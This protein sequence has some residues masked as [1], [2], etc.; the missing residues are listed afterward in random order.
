MIQLYHFTPTRS[1]AQIL[2]QGL[3]PSYARGNPRLLWACDYAR[4]QWAFEH[5]AECHGVRP[6]ALSL[7]TFRFSEE[8]LAAFSMPGVY[9][10]GWMIGKALLT[11]LPLYSLREVARQ[12]GIANSTLQYW[13]SAG[14]IAGSLTA[15]G[16]HMF[17]PLDIADVRA[18]QGQIKAN[19]EAGLSR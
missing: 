2:A 19:R 12:T 14:W 7:L 10:T 17:S 9:R 5:V 8:R 1:L 4:A 6:W 3:D 11:H 15:K 13:L 16:V 18:C